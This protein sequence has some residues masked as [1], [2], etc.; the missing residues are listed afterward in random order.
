MTLLITL[1]IAAGLVIS[2][3]AILL[4]AAW[5]EKDATGKDGKW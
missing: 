3:T 2:I 4:L 5:L 1:C